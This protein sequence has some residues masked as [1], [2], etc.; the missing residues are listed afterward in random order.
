[1][2]QTLSAVGVRTEELVRFI[3]APMKQQLN[4]IE[5][6]VNELKSKLRNSFGVM[7][8]KRTLQKDEERDRLEIESLTRQLIAL[9]GEL[10]GMTE[11]DQAVLSLHDRYLEEEQLVEGWQRDLSRARTVTE[12]CIAD[13]SVSTSP[14]LGQQEIPNAEALGQISSGVTGLVSEATSL[15]K[16]ARNLLTPASEPMQAIGKLIDDWKQSFLI[17]TSKYDSAKQKATSQQSLLKQIADTENRIKTVRTSLAAKRERLASLGTPEEEYRTLRQEWSSLFAKR[18]RL[19]SEKCVEL[20]SL[21]AK[22]IS[23]TL[24]RGHGIEKAQERLFSLMV[25]TKIRTRR[26][27]EVFTLVTGSDDA[28]TTWERILAELE[29]LIYAVSGDESILE[30]PHTPLL[31][32]AN[33]SKSDL[34]KTARKLTPQDWLE[35]SLVELEDK[36]VFRYQQRENEYIKFEDASAGQQATALLRVLL[37]QPGPPLIIDQPEEDLDN[38]VILEIVEE[39][40]KAK[41]NR[42]IIF[43]SHN[44]NIVVNGDADLVV[45][46]DYRTAGD[47]SGGKIKCLGAID[48]PEMRKEITVVMEGG[49]EAFRLRRDKYGF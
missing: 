8:E 16:Q 34:D 17:H 28:Q 40:W 15:V 11:E 48:V 43:T 29:S 30:L 12:R 7:Q 42:Q 9:R 13:L 25:G 46:C 45:C 18:A 37:N 33:Y 35:L 3:Q 14:A 31:D 38:Q 4:D 6:R 27:E 49:R 23:A 36:P 19:L 22:R 21:S 47:Q 1:M 32:S 44:A 24:N 10:K 41:K 2:G 26:H 5:V 20:T 39:I